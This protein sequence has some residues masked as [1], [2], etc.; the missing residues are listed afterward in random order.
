MWQEVGK[1][2]PLRPS[3]SGNG[4]GRGC[5]RFQVPNGDKNLPIKKKKKRSWEGDVE[6]SKFNSQQTKNVTYSKEKQNPNFFG[7]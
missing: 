3:P 1:G 4:A 5:G 7:R 6:G 2:M